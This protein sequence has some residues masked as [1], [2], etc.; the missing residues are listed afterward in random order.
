VSHW[1]TFAGDSSSSS[2]TQM[3]YYVGYQYFDTNGTTLT[4]STGSLP[5]GYGLSYT[6]FSYQN[7]NVPC[8]TVKPDGEV[9]VQ[10]EVYNQSPVAGTETV[11]LFVQFPGSSVSNRAGSSYKELKG[12][13]RVSLAGMGTSGS[14]KRITI[15]LR[16]KDLKYWDTAGNKWAV[17][18]GMVKV[19]V[20]PNASA[21]ASPCSGGAGVGCGLSDTFMVTQ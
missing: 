21:A 19:I 15:P 18:P 2:E 8:S 14:A 9:D 10:V 20:A 1:P 7:L 11:F 12:F 3:G 13:Y 17:E 16:V 5:F 4:P 6:T